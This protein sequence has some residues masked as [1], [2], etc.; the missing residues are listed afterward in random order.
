MAT[1]TAPSIGNITGIISEGI[2]E[3]FS[4]RIRAVNVELA[5]ETAVKVHAD[6]ITDLNTEQLNHGLKADGTT[7]GDYANIGY[8]GRLRPVD[9]YDTGDFHK[10]SHIEPFGKA[11]SLEFSDP[12][13]E[14]LM[15]L[16]GDAIA[17]LTEENVGVAAELIKETVQEETR[18]QMK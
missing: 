2:A 17:G 11:F 12:K 3:V 6:E 10:S 13:T 18:N 14:K 4:A 8:K 16:Y 1:A 7:T 15:N 9:L 5:I